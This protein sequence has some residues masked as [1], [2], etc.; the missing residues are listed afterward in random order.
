MQGR[1]RLAQMLAQGESF[2][3]NKKINL[4]T[5]S[6]ARLGDQPE[7]AT[8]GVCRTGG[9]F[10]RCWARGGEPLTACRL[11]QKDPEAWEDP[12]RS[13]QGSVHEELE[14]KSRTEAGDQME[15]WMNAAVRVAAA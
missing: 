6:Q 12:E 14:S 11:G 3:P 5:P 8:W 13:S 9:I 1:G 4:G 2:S 10:R 7:T 15:S